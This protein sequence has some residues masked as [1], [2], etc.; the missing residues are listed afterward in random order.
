MF[1][2][3]QTPKIEQ[4]FCGSIS[5]PSTKT[6][7]KISLAAVGLAAL[8][9]A[10]ALATSRS[11]SEYLPINGKAFDSLSM[12]ITDAVKKASDHS[13]YWER[14]TWVIALVANSMITLSWAYIL[15][16]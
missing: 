7:I 16:K 8:S 1:G 2:I 10:V 11:F 4:S 15:H 3:G 14:T 6:A 13:V 12:N 9:S 5:L